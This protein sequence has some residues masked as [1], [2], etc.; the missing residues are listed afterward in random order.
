MSRL[1]T[2]PPL[3]LL[4]HSNC[5]FGGLPALLQVTRRSGLAVPIVHTDSVADLPAALRRLIEQERVAV[6]GLLG[7]DGSAHHALNA[8]LH[9]GGA[10]QSQAPPAPIL[11]LRGG[12]M[13]MLARALGI[14]GSP[15]DLLGRF[16]RR[17]GSI[18][19][20]PIASVPALAVDSAR[21]GRRFGFIF[22]SA[23]TARLLLLHERRFGGGLLGLARLLGAAT[24]GAL[25]RSRFWIEHRSLLQ[26]EPVPLRV[27]GR[28][29]PYL[30]A[31]AA[32]VPVQL[33]GGWVTG[34]RAPEATEAAFAVR[35][36]Q[37]LAPATVLRRLPSL[38]LGLKSSG[39]LDF[40]EA[41]SLEL[42]G[43]FSLDG[44]V[45]SDPAA[46][47]NVS[48]YAPGLHVRFVVP[49]P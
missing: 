35:V 42:S 32:T 49:D 26:A 10:L 4:V 9:G 12:R 21:F 25:L 34:L 37:P 45:Y 5:R 46:P 36:V 7:G 18:H 1:A 41:R 39:I 38:V 24:L 48:V 19:D 13:N 22:G 29:L 23:L 27:D 2:R 8:W 14:G 11:L 40:P 31:A 16:L 30:A 20:L 44:E 33:L 47:G 6:L 43:D 28:S 15:L 17:R 3:G